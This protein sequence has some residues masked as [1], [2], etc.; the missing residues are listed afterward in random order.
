[1]PGGQGETTQVEA[2]RAIGAERTKAFTDAVV[3]IAMTLLILPLLESV[4]EASAQGLSV[5]DWAGEHVG[6][7]WTFALSFMLIA[8]F[9]INHHAILEPV[10]RLTQGL[11]WIDVGWMFM[12]VWM[13]VTTAMAGSQM[14]ADRAKFLAYV[15]PMLGAA[16]LA[17]LMARTVRR[18]A[19]LWADGERPTVHPQAVALSM[20][21]LYALAL[22][23]GLIM[24]GGSGFLAMFLLAGIAPLER[25]IARRLTPHA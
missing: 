9:W 18:R 7:I 15:L 10:E 8:T 25:V 5:G 24:P 11:L 14:A 3:A 4:S 13:P 19:D 22:G 16:A 23:V 20:A 2:R 1:M 12:I 6:Q 17:A 21:T